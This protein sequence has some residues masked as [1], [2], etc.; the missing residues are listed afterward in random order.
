MVE[1]PSCRLLGLLG[2][3][4]RN[5]FEIQDFPPLVSFGFLAFLPDFPHMNMAF[6][7]HSSVFEVTFWPFPFF[8]FTLPILLKCGWLKRP[9][10]P[11]LSF[12]SFIH[13]L[14]PFLPN[15]FERGFLSSI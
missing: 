5:G 9:S 3:F 15:A 10:S 14:K 7:N 13:F 8:F 12:E 2:G 6:C 1:V 11:L 4:V